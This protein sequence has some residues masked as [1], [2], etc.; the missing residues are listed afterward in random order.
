MPERS[1]LFLFLLIVALGGCKGN[2]GPA[3]SGGKPID[4]WL[5]ALSDPNPKQ[6]QRAVE[7]LGNVGASDPAVLSALCG[8]LQDQDAEVR[9]QAALALAKSGPDA[10]SAVEPLKTLSR[11]DP[12]PRVRSYA[13]KAVESLE[14]PGK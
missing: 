2:S 6:R 1:L 9:C 13:A 7:K 12:D 14:K 3:L 5:H 10:K 8:A 11:Q 4:E